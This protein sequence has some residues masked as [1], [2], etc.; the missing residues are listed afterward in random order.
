MYN[1]ETEKPRLFTESGQV[2]FLKV[3]DNV[4][5]LLHKAG[6]VRAQEAWTQVCGD[7]WIM[8]ACLDRLVE[9]KE[10]REISSDGVPGQ[11]R[12]FVAR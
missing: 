7:S 2:M 3:R 9:L 10:I 1:Y 12:V 6:A 4:K 8:L 11:H 5:E